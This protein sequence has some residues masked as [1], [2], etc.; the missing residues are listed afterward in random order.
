MIKRGILIPPIGI[1]QTKLG[2]NLFTYG[3][4]LLLSLMPSAILYWDKLY[5]PI[6]VLGMSP[7]YDNAVHSMVKLGIAESIHLKTENSLSGKDF[8]PMLRKLSTLRDQ[9]DERT[10]EAWAILSPLA[11][12]GASL[13]MQSGFHFSKSKVNTSAI[14]VA[15]KNALPV[16]ERDI[17]YEDLLEFKNSRQDQ[18]QRLHAEISQLSSRYINSYG[19]QTALEMSLS[20]LRLSLD[21][22][23]RVYSERWA[24]HALRDFS[25]AFAVSGLWPA[26]VSY[27]FN[28]EIDRAFLA[29]AGATIIH[30]AVS[31]II[32]NKNKGSPYLYSIDTIK[33]L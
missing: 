26:T 5:T 6:G 8:P 30:T 12:R 21:D 29:G 23:Q 3:D 33:A 11:K 20:D 22:V 13:A 15:L 27:L 31:S 17:P 25:I 19:D 1:T 4:G 10:G 18:L 24:I 16:P 28:A 14:E 2:E 9:L 32:S 7:N